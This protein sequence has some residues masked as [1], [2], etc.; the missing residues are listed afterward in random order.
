MDP[1]T[2]PN[3]LNHAPPRYALESDSEDEDLPPA[4]AYQSHRASASFSARSVEINV[5]WSGEGGAG[6]LVLV[7]NEAGVFGDGYIK[8]GRK[9]DGIVKRGDE[10]IAPL[11]QLSPDLVVL[12]IESS[13]PLSVPTPLTLA[14][15]QTLSPSQVIV[16]DQY[17]ASSYTTPIWAS[18]DP[19]E[20]NTDDH[21]IR[22]LSTSPTP[23]L[24][25]SIVPFS[26]PN[27]ILSPS[28]P[29][30]SLIPLSSPP[31]HLFILPAPRPTLR[32][33][34]DL[35][36]LL[37]QLFGDRLGWDG[38]GLGKASGRRSAG[39]KAGG[40]KKAEGAASHM[41]I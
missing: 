35:A 10:A 20:S 40:G 3:S 19:T 7:G 17:L 8:P 23:S 39:W 29:F 5:D 2:D 18:S 30:L 12:F 37:D 28:A 25:K 26:P 4:S 6:L 1:F 11:Y 34:G 15:L 36:S 24:P 16:I 32:L 41:Y 14:V 27:H 21:P 38:S 33:L 31:T 13:L 9:P 22:Y